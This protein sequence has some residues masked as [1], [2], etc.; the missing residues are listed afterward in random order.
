MNELDAFPRTPVFPR[1]EFA[2]RLERVQAALD[3]RNVELFLVFAP[4]HLFYL[5]GY[6]TF[7]SR[8]FAALMVPRRGMPTLLVRY[9]ESYLV[10]LYSEVAEVAIYDDY[11]D[12]LERL[13]AEVSRRGSARSLVAIEETAPA[14]T[15]AARKRLGHLLLH[16]DP[17]DGSGI[18]EQLRRVKSEREI[19]RMR[20]AAELTALGMRAAQ[21]ACFP[22]SS[23]NDVAAAAME[24]MVRAG[25]EYFPIDPIVTSGYRAG[26]PHTTFERRVLQRSDTVLLE[27]TGVSGRYVGPL[28][29]AVSLGEPSARV[30]RMA[31]LCLE[32]LKRAMAVMRPG[33]R[34]DEVDDACRRV[35]E[36]AG[37]YE[38][39]RKRTGYSVGFAFPPGWNEGHI[40]S[41]KQGDT[42]VLEPGMVFHVPPALRDY[43]VSCVGVSETIVITP[44]GC[45]NL[46][47]FPRELKIV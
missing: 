16:C 11:E 46:V 6:Q 9:L 15:A 28:M 45:E 3:R 19:A 12:P 33:V 4:E 27:M 36:R 42:T 5:T 13:A 25:S 32:G 24:A 1:E 44:D 22:G 29:R 40:I 37:L 39:F 43:G 23:E 20:A 38:S 17:R 18:I 7:A 34:A 35:I 2:A 41:L 26:I 21:Q 8:T 14:M 10:T 31:D 30:R 47:E